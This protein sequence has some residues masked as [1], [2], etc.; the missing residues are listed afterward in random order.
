MRKRFLDVA[1]LSL[2][3]I[4]HITVYAANE[5]AEVHDAPTYKE[6]EQRARERNGGKEPSKLDIFHELQR[7][8]AEKVGL[9]KSY[10]KPRIVEKGAKPEIII[11]GDQII[12]N[13]EKIAIGEP[14]SRWRAIL[15]PESRKEE[16]LSSTYFWEQ[17]GLKLWV[18]GKSN[19]VTTLDVFLNLEPKEPWEPLLPDGSTMPEPPDFRPKKAFSGYLELDGYG[20][21]AK[22]KFWEIRESSSSKRNLR[23]GTWPDDCSH[24]HGG[25]NKNA[26]LYFRLNGP[27][28]NNSVY[29]FSISG[30]SEEFTTQKAKVNKSPSTR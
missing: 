28:E 16:G 23:C 26:D 24:P 3:W 8:A 10:D 11:K 17:L 30:D 4:T 15:G 1:F 18:R 29:E 27:T 5:Q 9:I 20:I 19:R 14:V 7:K 25:F 2:L 13:G 21:D 12:I 6:L 22:T